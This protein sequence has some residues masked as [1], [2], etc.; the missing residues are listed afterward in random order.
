[1][2]RIVTALLVF[3]VCVGRVEAATPEK[4][5]P[6]PV[7]T[8]II[9]FSLNDTRFSVVYA[10][11]TTTVA[12][13]GEIVQRE[14]ESA[15]EVRLNLTTYRGMN[16]RFRRVKSYLIASSDGGG[17]LKDELD[18]ENM[19]VSYLAWGIVWH[20]ATRTRP[21]HYTGRV[22]VRVEG[23]PYLTSK[24][25]ALQRLVPVTSTR[26]AVRILKTAAR[27]YEKSPRNRRDDVRYTVSPTNIT[28]TRGPAWKK[29]LESSDIRYGGI[30][31][32]MVAR[33]SGHMFVVVPGLEG[34]L[35][36][37]R[38]DKSEA[39]MIIRAIRFLASKQGRTMI[40]VKPAWF[41]R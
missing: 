12:I 6:A 16:R 21:Q 36:W 5:A 25:R 32:L 13:D 35:G 1:M 7:R 15:H 8:E 11:D 9:T 29:M 34:G 22:Q 37:S 3:A 38:T 19:K 4:S 27:K 24:D 31:L 39:V 17:L 14:R 10:G 23:S 18:R 2:Y 20:P 26:Q 28:A 40:S 30:H 33:T 41:G